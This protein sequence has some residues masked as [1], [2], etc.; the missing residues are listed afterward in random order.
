MEDGVP[1]AYRHFEQR[2]ISSGAH[3]DLNVVIEVGHGD[4]VVDRVKDVVGVVD[5]FEGA[6]GDPRWW[7]LRRS[8]VRCQGCIDAR[9]VSVGVNHLALIPS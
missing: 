6:Y 2:P 7:T 9:V 3:D 4:R 8:V 5:S 1:L